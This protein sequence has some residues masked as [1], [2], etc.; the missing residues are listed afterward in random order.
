[1]KYKAQPTEVEAN[2]IT[3]VLP[4]DIN[5]GKISVFVES[6]GVVELDGKM[7]GNYEPGVGDYFIEEGEDGFIL[8]AEVFETKYVSTDTDFLQAQEEKNTAALDKQDNMKDKPEEVDVHKFYDD[9]N[10][11]LGG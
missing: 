2:K 11:A 7:M 1:M 3:A 4:V 10:K 8:P 9:R 5:T 6:K